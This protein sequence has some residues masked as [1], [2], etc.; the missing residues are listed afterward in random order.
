MAAALRRNESFDVTNYRLVR[1]EYLMGENI[2]TTRV[3]IESFPVLERQSLLELHPVKLVGGFITVD[4][5]IG[6]RGCRFCLSRRHQLW[7]TVYGR[8]IRFKPESLTPETVCRWLS[9]MRSFWQAR[10]PVRF[11]HNTDA[12]FQWEFGRRLY[13]MVPDGHPFIMLTR[14]PVSKARRS[15]FQGQPNLLLKLTITPPSRLLGIDTDLAPLI[16]TTHKIPPE[17]LYVLIGPIVKDNLDTVPLIIEKLP[18]VTWIDVKPLTVSGI[19]NLDSRWGPH[20]RRI[21]RLREMARQKGLKVTDYF[22]CVLRRRL[23]RAFYKARSARGY[24]LQSCQECTNNGVCFSPV[25]RRQI[26]QSLTETAADIHL[27]VSSV[28]WRN[29]SMAVETTVPA[30]RGD[31]T[32]LSEMLG[33]PVTLS[34]TSAGSQGGCFSLE[35]TMI[36]ERWEETGMFPSTAVSDSAKRIYDQLMTA[37]RN[38]EYGVT[39]SG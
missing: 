36:H 21:Q 3:D 22:G 16:D 39:D 12:A 10:V 14:F 7:R 5:H 31:E 18:E 30:S 13:E 26:E 34:T 35:D 32:Y 28:D 23:T 27:P 9:G 1:L 11:G 15:M 37:M 19:P 29:N 8:N 6:C 24:L 25:N 20:P 4:Q 33:V 2:T 38:A 17:N